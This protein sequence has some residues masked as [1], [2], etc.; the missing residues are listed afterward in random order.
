MGLFNK[1]KG[2]KETDWNQ[3]YHAKPQFYEKTDGTFFGA[4][5]ITEG[6]STILPKTPQAQYLV[7]GNPVL[8]WKLVLCSTTKQ[9]IIGESYY[10]TALRKMDKYTLDTNT[11][12]ILIKALCLEELEELIE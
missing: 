6:V 10:F 3:A 12:S 9:A 4:I 2:K 11:Q 1:L 7:D 8:E 5:S